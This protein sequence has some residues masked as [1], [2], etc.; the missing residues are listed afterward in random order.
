MEHGAQPRW[1]IF[2]A[3]V[4]CALMLCLAS[5]PAVAQEQEEEQGQRQN[6]QEAM[7]GGGMTE[8]RQ[9]DDERAREH[10][11]IA[12]AYYDEGRFREAA[13][14][15]EE[16]YELSRRPELLYNAYIAYRDAHETADAART[17]ESF[18][19][20]SPDAPDR[21]NLQARL[22]EL[23]RAVAEEEAEQERL[24][25]AQAQAEAERRRAEAEAARAAQAE[26]QPE[27]WPWIILGVGGATA[28]AGAVV[29]GLALNDANALLE[30][31]TDTRCMVSSQENLDEMRNEAK[32][33]ALAADIMLFGGGA[34]A[35]TGL[36]LGLALGLPG[37]GG[38]TADEPQATLECGPGFCGGRLRGSF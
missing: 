1:S 22:E 12:T 5:A 38:E 15:F 9:L 8:G 31:C 20:E 36:I 14:Q 26:S 17:L 32:N 2:G 6:M 37:G 28:I 35:V 4:A 16:A 24:A 34:I 21:V 27:I 23:R 30:M 11:R 25:T 29:A 13:A 3:S 33:L 18:L 10:F 7:Q 19:A